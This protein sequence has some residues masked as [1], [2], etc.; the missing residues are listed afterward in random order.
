MGD[1]AGPAI[2]ASVRAARE[3]RGWSRE[4]LAYHSGVSWSAIAQVESGRRRDIRLTT[5]TALARALDMSV[6]HLVGGDRATRPSVAHRALVY[7]DDDAFLAG[8]LPFLAKGVAASERVLAATT[9]SQTRRLRRALGNDAGRVEFVDSSTWYRSPATSLRNCLAWIDQATS[10]GAH[11]ARFLGEPI[12]SDWTKPEL[13]AWQRYESL[14]NLSLAA[15]PI[16]IVCPYD[17]RTVPSRIVRRALETHPEQIE[18]DAGI[19]PSPQFRDP[20]EFL[21][22]AGL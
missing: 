11:W 19:V 1:V 22:D 13:A 14:I 16:T 18:A 21:L 12:W 17:S 5:I 20:I 4:E 3:R 15:S 7:D 6:D 9:R 10:D 8:A 2:G